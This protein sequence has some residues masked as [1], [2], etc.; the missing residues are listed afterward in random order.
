MIVGIPPVAQ[1]ALRALRR[2]AL[3]S[4][5]ALLAIAIGA[6]AVVMV[7]ALS[8]GAR[9]AIQEQVQV[10]G[11]NLLVV[12]SGSTTQGGVRQGAASR[13][14]LT[15]EDAAAM[16]EAVSNAV[17][18]APVVRR[19]AQ[20]VYG[21]RN[22]A[23]PVDGA[24]PE[25]VEAKDWPVRAGR[26]FSEDEAG[27]ALKVA[28]LGGTVAEQLF[29]DEDPVGQVIRMKHVPFTVI[30]I[31]EG[32]GQSAWGQ[33]QDDVVVIPLR[34]ARHK[35]LGWGGGPRA[36]SSI[37][38]KVPLPAL[39]PEASAQIR[40]LL[41]ER[42]RLGPDQEDDFTVRNLTEFL[43]A[44]GETGRTARALLA[45]AAAVSLLLGGIGILNVMLASVTARTRE[46]GIRM[47]VGARTRDIR[48]QFLLEALA[49]GGA[50]GLAG[51]LLGVGGSAVVPFVAGWPA[52]V[53][54]PGVALAFAAAA[55]T[56]LVFGYFPA[57][58][59]SLLEPIEALGS[60]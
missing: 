51:I 8:S 15:E 29:G 13:L 35:L 36:V 41:R 59:A 27:D 19:S 24:T 52:S 34:T 10:L 43:A 53:G 56:G 14:S 42:H 47:V 31:L 23:A 55:L 45:A 2:H 46:I 17:A 12:V 3:R 26:F 33:D 9:E 48:R 50:G 49:L 54:I 16:A 18:V 7:V 21:N 57:R 32:K 11:G 44:Q 38:V 39:L 20:I 1:T 30:G 58:R 6:A 40:N 4:A 60:E 25:Y 28:V 5:L 37:T 22:W